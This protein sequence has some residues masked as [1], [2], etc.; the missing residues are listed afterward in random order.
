[1]KLEFPPTQRR[2]LHC[3]LLRAGSREI[4]G[5]LM[6]EQLKP[7]HFRIVDFSVDA[8]SGSSAHFVRGAEEH[9]K[10]LDSFF[11]RTGADYSRYNYLG[12]WHSHPNFP[13]L[14]SPQDMRSMHSLVESE[15]N[16]PFSVL[17]IVRTKWRVTLECSAMLFQR[18]G[19]RSEV[20]IVH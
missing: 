2:V 4:G 20:E 13:A 19:F 6:G 1:M 18:G 16:I 3:S 15:D 11:S 8:H 17:L 5:I 14:P 9:R 7:G 12:E 10:A